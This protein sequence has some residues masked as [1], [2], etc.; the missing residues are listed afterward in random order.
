MLVRATTAALENY[1]TAP[2]SSQSLNSAAQLQGVTSVYAQGNSV[3]Q[4]VA[5]TSRY[6]LPTVAINI[7]RARHKMYP[8]HSPIGFCGPHGR[9]QRFQGLER[10]PVRTGTFGASFRALAGPLRELD[11]YRHPVLQVSPAAEH[12]Q[13]LSELD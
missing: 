6:M 11:A 1:A 2:V 8:V 9:T 10:L 12:G 5:R 13:A 3:R 4:S 7:A